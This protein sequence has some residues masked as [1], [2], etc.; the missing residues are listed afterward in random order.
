MVW[1]VELWPVYKRAVQTNNSMEGWHRSINE[2][3][4]VSSTSAL[5]IKGN[6]H[7]KLWEEYETG[8]RTISMK[9][10][11]KKCGHLHMK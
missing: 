4:F 6:R 1:P 8:S 3:A 11:L 2:R 7:F 5:R 9:R 10:F